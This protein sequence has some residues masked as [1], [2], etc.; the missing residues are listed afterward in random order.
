MTSVLITGAA[1]GIGLS[2]VNDYLHKGYTVWA[3]ARQ[4][5]PE[6]LA[7]NAEVITNI[8]VT[9]ELGINKLT[10]ALEGQSL[11]III[12]CAGLLTQETLADMDFDRIQRQW[13]VNTLGPL[14]VIQALLDNLKEGSKIAMISSRMGSL[15]DNTSGSRYGYRISKAALNAASVSLAYDLKPRGI[16]VAILHPGFVLTKMTNFSGD[17]TPDSAAQNIAT[18]IDELNL[19]N[20]GTFWHANGKTL[21]W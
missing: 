6:L 19:T 2:L 9:T 15:E 12:N 13:E 1:S 16:A 18:R 11:G 7:T 17:I 14:R 5:T 10:Q 3:T 21:P 20:T 8:D 4:A